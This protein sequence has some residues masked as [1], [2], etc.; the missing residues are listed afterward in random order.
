MH[1][2]LS[3]EKRA[4]L[5]VREVKNVR[6]YSSHCGSELGRSLVD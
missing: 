2:W 3:E 6:R 4:L 1:Q 5:Q